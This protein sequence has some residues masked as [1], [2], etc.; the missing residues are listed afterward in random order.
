MVIACPH[1]L[2]LAIPLVVAISTSITA[3]NGI[4]VRNRQAFETIRNISAIVF[5]KTGTLTKGEFEVNEII[6]EKDEKEFLR[7]AAAVEQNSEHIIAEAIVKYTKENDVDIPESDDFSASTGKG[8]SAIVDG[9]QVRI[10]GPKLLKE[11]NAD[12]DMDKFAEYEEKGNTVVFVFVDDE[13]F[14]AVALSD[15]PREESADAIKQFRDLGIKVYMLT[16]DSEKVASAIAEEL[17][18]DEYFAE[19]MPDEKA[20]KVNELSDQGE[21]VAMVGDGINDAPALARADIGIA[22]GAG[23]SV[24]IESAEI[25][26]VKSNIQNVIDTIKFSEDNHKKMI[27]NLWWAAGYN[28]VALPLAAGVLS[29][30]GII[31]QPAVGA[32]LMSASTVIVAINAQTLRKKEI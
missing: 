14:G 3:K 24:A 31:I 18:V 17:G 19:I 4:L 27:Q 6:T 22:I 12:I 23:T 15:Q 8:V 11:I 13:F 25:V 2:G 20:D 29:W 5:D 28:I 21:T 10:G 16:G 7:Y 26:L 32:L 1:A 9:K 30:V